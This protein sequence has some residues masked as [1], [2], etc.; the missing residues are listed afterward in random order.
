MKN[1][2]ID[3]I[4]II[5][6]SNTVHSVNYQSITDGNKKWINRKTIGLLYNNHHHFILYTILWMLNHLVILNGNQMKKKKS[7]MIDTKWLSFLCQ[8]MTMFTWVEKTIHLQPL[9]FWY[10]CSANKDIVIKCMNSNKN[11][12]IDDPKNESSTKK[13]G[14]RKSNK[15]PLIWFCGKFSHWKFDN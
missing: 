15:N 7:L 1:F 10:T 14:K 11:I 4:I 2:R 8:S 12:R 9:H 13:L 5:I 6:I 3:Q